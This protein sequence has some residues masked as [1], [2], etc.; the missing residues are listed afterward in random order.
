MNP[1]QRFFSMFPNGKKGGGWNPLGMMM[2]P[3]QGMDGMWGTGDNA[4]GGLDSY[5]QATVQEMLNGY[6]SPTTEVEDEDYVN[7][8]DQKRTTLPYRFV[9]I[10][11]YYIV[12]IDL[13]KE[14][15]TTDVR[16]FQS[17]GRMMV[18]LA[19]GKEQLIRL[20]GDASDQQTRAKLRD[21]ILEVLIPKRLEDFSK[22]IQVHS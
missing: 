2:P 22:E 5:I 3:M 13:S 20:P 21:G 10:H 9:E 8:E 4:K 1:L 19:S 7:R 15:Q 17:P 6:N 14:E 18:R 11:D 12:R 16:I